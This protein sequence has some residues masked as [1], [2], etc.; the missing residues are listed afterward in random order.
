VAYINSCNNTPH[1][2]IEIKLKAPDYYGILMHT[3]QENPKEKNIR[4]STLKEDELIS[5]FSCIF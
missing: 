5:N 1:K 2:A 4:K 3:D